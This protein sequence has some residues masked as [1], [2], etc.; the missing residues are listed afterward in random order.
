[1]PPATFEKSFPDRDVVQS[2]KGDPDKHERERKI[3]LKKKI[4]I[5]IKKDQIQDKRNFLVLM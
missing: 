5:I 1:M 4:I 2:V 3:V